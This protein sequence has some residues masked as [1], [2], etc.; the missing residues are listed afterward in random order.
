MGP[1]RAE[2]PKDKP[3]PVSPR[4]PTHVPENKLHS[5]S[6][7]PRP[8]AQARGDKGTISEQRKPAPEAMV[9]FTQR[10]SSGPEPRGGRAFGLRGVQGETHGGGRA[11]QARPPS[12]LGRRGAWSGRQPLLRPKRA[13]L[14]RSLVLPHP[15]PLPVQA[16]VLGTFR[17]SHRVPAKLWRPHV[18]SGFCSFW[19]MW[20]HEPSSLPLSRRRLAVRTS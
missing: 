11:R 3:R 4:Q 1:P 15:P 20:S 16:P 10:R 7:C 6:Q 12:V 2:S 14:S 18:P 9:H 19:N 8:K 13:W 5:E 17:R